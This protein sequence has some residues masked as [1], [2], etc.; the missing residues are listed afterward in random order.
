MNKLSKILFSILLIYEPFAYVFFVNY[1]NC[2][3]FFSWNFC[4]DNSLGTRIVLFLV[5]PAIIVA[6]CSMWSGS[7]SK[8]T[9]KKKNINIKQKKTE[10][11]TPKVKQQFISPADSIR[12]YWLKIGELSGTAQRSEYWIATIFYVFILIVAIMGITELFK[13]GHPDCFEEYFFQEDQRFC[14]RYK[15]IHD[16]IIYLVGLIFIIPQI[17]LNAR[18]WRDIGFS[19]F[20]A[21][22]PLFVVVYPIALGVYGLIQFV[23]FCFP[24]KLINNPYRKTNT[25]TSKEMKFSK[26]D[27]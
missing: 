26:Q 18:R 24:S 17:T 22:I 3:D 20:L 6:L 9:K 23:A 19:G 8:L 12:N 25:K 21:I 7:L 27:N 2:R 11:I 5:I 1:R 13:I 16:L 10:K 15:D 4:S 14:L